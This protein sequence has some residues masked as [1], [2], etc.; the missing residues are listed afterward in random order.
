MTITTKVILSD[1]HP[2]ILGGLRELLGA[3]PDI[4]VVGEVT[5]GTAALKLIRDALPDI[6][7]LDI[8]MPGL[9]GLSVIRH[10]RDEGLPVRPIILTLHE[11]RG[12]LRQSLDAGAKAFVLKRSAGEYLLHAIRTVLK[13][14]IYIDP[15]LVELNAREGGPKLPGRD[16]F[17]AHAQLTERETQVLKL[18]ALG[19]AQKEI[20]GRLE[21]SPKSVETYKTRASG[22]LGLRTRADVVRYAAAQGWLADL[23]FQPKT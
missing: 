23:G 2:F 22:K 15:T 7:I 13:G 4:H 19:F 11:D 10:L 16:L 5:S 20:A 9:S 3:Q 18:V 17:D 14:D 12:Y 6:A 21:I 1:D 8:S